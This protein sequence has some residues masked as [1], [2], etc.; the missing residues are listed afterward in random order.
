M[1]QDGVWPAGVA[2]GV[3]ERLKL[4]TCQPR[5]TALRATA[6]PTKPLPPKMQTFMAGARRARG[7]TSCSDEVDEARRGRRGRDRGGAAGCGWLQG[8]W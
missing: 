1:T 3:P 2:N 4:T 5:A 7:T 6:D 8:Y